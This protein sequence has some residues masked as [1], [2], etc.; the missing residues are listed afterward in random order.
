MSSKI[1]VCNDVGP[2][3]EALTR[4]KEYEVIAEDEV[5]EQFKIKGDNNRS[6]WFK[7]YYFVSPG[8]SV[9]VIVSWKFDD[10]VKD[11][12]ANSLE[13]IEISIIFNDG[14]KRW[15][16]ICTKTG[17]LDY[18]ERNMDGNVYLIE[19]QIIVRNFSNEVVK[20]H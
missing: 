16:S 4:G 3:L 12:S 1:V 11:S 10:V 20:I 5:K 6:R 17:L 13:H 19:Y 18:L 8:I 7:K 15:C 14:Q 9:P 2:Y